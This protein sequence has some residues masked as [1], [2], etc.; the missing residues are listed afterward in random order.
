MGGE[1]NTQGIVEITTGMTPLQAVI[2]AGGFKETAQLEETIVIRKGEE[3]RPIPIRVDLE[4][5]FY[6]KEGEASFQLQSFDIV[7]VPKFSIAKAN[8]FVER[9]IQKLLLFRGWDFSIGY[10]LYRFWDDR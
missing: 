6:G 4:K 3:N 9:Y 10:D 1:V 8:K 5:A 7:Y 2:N